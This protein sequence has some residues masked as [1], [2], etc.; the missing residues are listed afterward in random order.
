[1]G[2]EDPTGEVLLST[3]QPAILVSLGLQGK[4]ARVAKLALAE[5]V[6]LVMP[7]GDTWNLLGGTTGV[8]HVHD[9]A[10]ILKGHNFDLFNR[11]GPFPNHEYILPP[12]PKSYT[13]FFRK[14]T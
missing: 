3:L 4:V 5:D 10:G 11:R 13:N 9:D 14:T 6:L 7:E 1:V 2:P 8:A 12:T